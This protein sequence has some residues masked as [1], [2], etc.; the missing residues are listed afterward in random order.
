MICK[1]KRINEI[2]L[3]ESQYSLDYLKSLYNCLIISNNYIDF[4]KYFIESG[5][6]LIWANPPHWSVIFIKRRAGVKIC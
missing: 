5:D 4:L 3:G 6:R 1:Y 2:S